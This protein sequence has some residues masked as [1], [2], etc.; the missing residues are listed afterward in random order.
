MVSTTHGSSLTGSYR[1]TKGASAP[2]LP[3]REARREGPGGGAGASA[4]VTGGWWGRDGGL[5]SI[6]NGIFHNK[7]ASSYWGYPQLW[8]PPI[9]ESTK[10]NA[11]Q[12]H[13]ASYSI[14]I[15]LQVLAP[16]N[17]DIRGYRMDKAS[18]KWFLGMGYS[19]QMTILIGTHDDS[20]VD[21]DVAHFRANPSCAENDDRTCRMVLAVRRC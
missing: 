10:Q 8:K 18:T 6:F 12:E 9:S 7:K 15:I 17:W 21:L 19:H 14:L 11:Q 20:S 16:K 5:S 13:P 4:G 2:G 1:F 3:P